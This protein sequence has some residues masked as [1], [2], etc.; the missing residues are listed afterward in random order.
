[1]PEALPGWAT[2]VPLGVA[3]AR[4]AMITRRG[5]GMTLA[6]AGFWLAMAG[7]ATFAGLDPWRLG[8]FFLVG[9]ALVYPAGGL[10]NRAFGGD[11]TARGS[12]LR[13]LVG[14]IVVGQM[15]GWPLLVALLWLRTDL[16]AF[17][18]AASLGVHF[19]PYGWL[20]RAPAYYLLGIASVA[21]ATV[22]QA[23]APMTA[24][25]TIALSMAVLYVA[26]GIAVLRQNRRDA[27]DAEIASP[28]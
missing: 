16:I 19:L 8:V 26:A 4:L 5:I 17:A 21:V 15:L 10:C 20:Y 27:A 14:A 7:V 1:V 28:C 3:R 24:N 25:V 13:G 2:R 11:L 18:L 6:S 12:E 23:L 22:L 9:G